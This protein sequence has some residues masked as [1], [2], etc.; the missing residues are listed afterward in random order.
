MAAIG[1]PQKRT[2][3]GPVHSPAAVTIPLQKD[4]KRQTT[5]KGTRH[6]T[7]R[8]APA[9]TGELAQGQ[10]KNGNGTCAKTKLCNLEQNAKCSL[11]SY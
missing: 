1:G 9:Q 6:P 2:G 10:L 4:S 11:P 8:T 5:P 7:I 3:M